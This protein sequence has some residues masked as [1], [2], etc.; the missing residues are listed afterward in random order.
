MLFCGRE[1]KSIGA[2]QDTCTYRR[3]GEQNTFIVA[4]RSLWCNITVL[5]APAAVENNNDD[6]KDSFC[7][8]LEQ[9]LGQSP[10]YHVKI[11]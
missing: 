2:K 4:L 3:V 7:E 11:L 5:N 6:L 10:K 8:E 1:M 9:V